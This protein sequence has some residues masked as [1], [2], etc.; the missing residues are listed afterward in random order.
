MDKAE[1]KLKEEEVK[2]H[3]NGNFTVATAKART[4]YMEDCK[5]AKWAKVRMMKKRRHRNGRKQ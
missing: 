5:I 2:E 1:A 4:N 3:A